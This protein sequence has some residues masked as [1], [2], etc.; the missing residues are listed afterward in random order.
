MYERIAD[1]T[2]Y[3]AVMD[4]YNRQ[5]V[6]HMY[7]IDDLLLVTVLM[8]TYFAPAEVPVFNLFL[9]KSPCHVI[10][11]L[12]NKNRLITLALVNKQTN[13]KQLK[14]VLKIFTNCESVLSL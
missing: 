1:V 8:N 10:N 12:Q 5:V 6:F 4:F 13:Y 14:L 3:Q 9:E 11:S 7:Y 2:N